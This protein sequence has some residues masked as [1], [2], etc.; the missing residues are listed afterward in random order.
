M[1]GERGEPIHRI[2]LVEGPT[3]DKGLSKDRAVEISIFLQRYKHGELC[4]AAEKRKLA[5][6]L[7][8]AAPRFSEPASEADREH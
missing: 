2:V 3:T 8:R 6:G 7:Q 4:S 5:L 1:V